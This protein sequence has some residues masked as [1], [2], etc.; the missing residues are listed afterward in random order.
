VPVLSTGGVGAFLHPDHHGGSYLMVAHT[1][2]HPP[3]W[4]EHSRH[5]LRPAPHLR[6]YVGSIASSAITGIIFH[7]H[8]T[9]HCVHLIAWIMIGVSLTLVALTL[10]DRT[11]PTRP[12]H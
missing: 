9:D 7:T 3:K 5:R 2:L 11:L 12:E 4:F 8:V 10:A 1:D 6:L